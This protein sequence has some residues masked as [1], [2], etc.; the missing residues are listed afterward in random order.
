MITKN[1]RSLKILV[2]TGT[3]FAGEFKKLR[4]T[5][6]KQIYSTKSDTEAAFAEPTKRS[7]TSILNR[8]IEVYGYE[9][10]HKLSQMVTTL[11]FRRNFLM[12]SI[13][14]NVKNSDS[15]SIL[16]SKSLR[17]DQKPKFKIGDKFRWCKYDLPFRKDYTPHFTRKIFKKILISSRK[18]PTY[19]KMTNRTTL[20]VVNFIKNNWSK[21]FNSRIVQ[22]RVGIQCIC[23]N[24]SRQNPQFFYEFF[25]GATKYESS[26]GG[27]N[28]GK[29][30]PIN[31]PKCYRGKVHVFW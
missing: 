31:V 17:E 14:K 22:Y 7:F 10:I 25:T 1:N 13:P 18:P 29:I 5:E 20:F 4:K 11:N 15:L 28:F 6:G 24:F 30:L 16:Y 8:Y 9:D 12:D 19:T 23:T 21:S 26:M 3:E 27:F 2:N